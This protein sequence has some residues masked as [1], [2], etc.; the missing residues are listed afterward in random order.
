MKT[1]LVIG[2]PRSASRSTSDS[3]GTY[4]ASHLEQHGFSTVKQRAVDI[5]KRD[6]TELIRSVDECDLIIVATPLYVDS[7]PAPLTRVLEILADAQL[8]PKRRRLLA[9]VNC[10]F[11]E[12]E[13][14][15]PALAILKRFGELNGF[16]WTGG[17]ALG[18][19]ELIGGKRLDTVGRPA[20]NVVRALDL[21]VA[22]LACDET[23]PTDAGELMRTRMI[24]SRLYTFIGNLNWKRRARKNGVAKQLR[25]RPYDREQT[26]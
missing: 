2:S 20:R 4:V 9:I 24:P 14:N 17:L 3:L 23:V 22:A 11:P 21:S 13:H 10:G 8:S 19:G 16:E 5:M 7:L 25:D 18:A 6:Q 12:S 26:R 1:L 15:E